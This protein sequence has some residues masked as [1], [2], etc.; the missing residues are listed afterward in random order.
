MSYI[1]KEVASLESLELKSHTAVLTDACNTLF[2]SDSF[3]LYDDAREFLASKNLAYLALVSAHPDQQL[4]R[5]RKEIITAHSVHI[6]SRPK[7]VKYGLYHQ[8][9]QKMEER[10]IEHI[11]ILGD[12]W[13]MDVSVGKILASRKRPSLAVDA[14]HVV[15]PEAETK[16]TRFDR[17]LQPIETALFLGLTAVGRQQLRPEKLRA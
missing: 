7:W 8:A 6:P 13:F 12:R 2:R 14:V 16:K 1:D 3:E 15:R 4:A 5:A 11:M 17:L 9:L 10:E